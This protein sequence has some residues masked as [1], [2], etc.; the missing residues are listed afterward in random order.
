MKTEFKFIKE[1]VEECKID[2]SIIVKDMSLSVKAGQ[3]DEAFA[4][5]P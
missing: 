1:H 4:F 3:E 2:S 5:E